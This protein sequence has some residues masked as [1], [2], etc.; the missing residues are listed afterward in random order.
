MSFPFFFFLEQQQQQQQQQRV[1]DKEKQIDFVNGT[2]TA[3]ATINA[4]TT[5]CV[6]VLCVSSARN[7][8]SVEKKYSQST[9]TVVGVRRRSLVEG[10]CD[11]HVSGVSISTTHNT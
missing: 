4:A 8:M 5:T 1:I 10:Q 9:Y 2:T 7:E 3:A 11:T 6:L